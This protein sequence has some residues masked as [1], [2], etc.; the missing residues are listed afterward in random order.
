MKESLR[1]LRD[2]TSDNFKG[3]DHKDRARIF[4]DFA[5]CF[6]W[7]PSDYL[8]Q[9][10]GLP[11]KLN[12]HLI[13][14]HG[15]ENAAVISF[16][17]ESLQ[18]DD[19][20]PREIK[21]LLEI[22]YNNLVDLHLAVD[23][24]NVSIY[25]NRI[26]PP[27]IRKISLAAPDFETLSV[28][29][30]RDF[31]PSFPLSNLPSLDTVL[32]KTIDYWKRFLYS[33]ISCKN[34]NESISALFN[35]IIF[36]RAVEDHYK[37]KCEN[38]FDTL[39][40]TWQSSDSNGNNLPKIFKESLRKF[41]AAKGSSS[42]L[43]F[44]LLKPFQNLD[45]STIRELIK[46]FYKIKQTPYEYNFALMSRH[47]LSRIY[48]K[49]VAL[50]R[51][52]KI[53]TKSQRTLFP[54]DLP[55]TERNKAS[56]SIY[57]PQFIARFFCRFI[58][59]FFPLKDFRKLKIADPACGSGIFLRTFVE[60]KI[61][62]DELT[63]KEIEDCFKNILGLDVD[64]N[65]CQAC[66]LSL[67]LLHLMRT[68]KLPSTKLKILSEE[69][70]R[71]YGSN[72]EM[73]KSYDAVTGNPPFV[74]LESQTREMQ[75]RVRSFLSLQPLGRSDLYLAIFQL[76]MEMV[77]PQG[78]LAFVLPHTFLIGKAPMRLRKK[79]K[80]NFWLHCIVDLSAIHVFEDFS[81]YIILI[82]A[83]R[84]SF[85]FK[86]SPSCKVVICRDFVGNALQ[87]CL[88]NISV[89]NPYYSVFE[90][91]QDYFGDSPW[92]L[93]NSKEIRLERKLKSM[94]KID[95]FLFV[96]EGI[97]TGHDSVYIIPSNKVP[98]GEEKLYIP[99]LHDREIERYITPKSSKRSVY[100]PY[101]N[102]K[103]IPRE[104]LEKTKK[105][106]SYLNK[107]YDRLTASAKRAWPYLHYPIAKDLLKP[108]II[109]PHLVLSPRFALDTNG[110]YAISHAPFMIPREKDVDLNLLKFF[111]AVL[112]FLQLVN[113]R[114]KKGDES[115]DSNI[116]ELVLKCYNL[117]QDEIDILTS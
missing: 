63:T 32:I 90:V 80:E 96:R 11:H 10:Y 92:V 113:E 65:A 24:E 25:F 29:V 55:E 37:I 13:V 116:D 59:N 35:S 7:R 38:P 61:S 54:I 20:S 30:F 26:E 100:Y 102:G 88:E 45:H 15:L 17:P 12:G 101:K 4:N 41:K 97:I 108:K 8:E 98:S 71:F 14:E 33:E 103:R 75:K 46:D 2:I 68:D 23:R 82:I 93:L 31:L 53:S 86:A 79:L 89:E 44:H 60:K 28:K 22:S 67:S 66:K 21:I 62:N 109:S 73:K 104:Q 27:E 94:S 95:D 6:G 39:L 74:R 70:I 3:R 16:I 91:D 105:T 5:E 57:T 56:G 77:K 1:I 84:K 19:I 58:E 114:I 81:T 107:N 49:Y 36:V 18:T 64:E 87:D 111:V 99:F 50:L 42:L 52:E 43:D 72:P 40:D 76:A 47:A 83:Q 78:F 51:Q 48:E 115:L 110:S 117:G 34:K 106:W 9:E 69:A 85:G 112:N